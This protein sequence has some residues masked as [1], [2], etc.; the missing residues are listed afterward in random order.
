[1]TQPLAL[2]LYDKLLPGSQLVNRLQDLKYRVQTVAAPGLL[3]DCAEQAKPMV[4]LADLESAGG[5]VCAAIRRLKQ[6]TAT[7][8]L[9]VI[10]FRGEKAVDWEAAAKA[11]GATL[12]VSESAILSHLAQFLEQALQVE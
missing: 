11:A 8:H 7:R 10:A 3:V 1:M 4:V 5:D 9:P 12:I 6:N 2:V